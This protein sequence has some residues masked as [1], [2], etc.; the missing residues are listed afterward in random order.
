MSNVQPAESGGDESMEHILTD[1]RA[2]GQRV[3]WKMAQDLL[4]KKGHR[5]RAS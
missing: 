3:V 2:S 5:P 4:T 1:C